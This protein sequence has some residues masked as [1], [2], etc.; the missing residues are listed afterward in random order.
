MRIER[1]AKYGFATDFTLY[2]YKNGQGKAISETISSSAFAPIN[3]SFENSPIENLFPE[4]GGL[5][6][7]MTMIT[8][9]EQSNKQK[10][11]GLVHQVKLRAQVTNN[12][13]GGF[14]LQHTGTISYDDRVQLTDLLVSYH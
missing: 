9:S 10:Q 14:G 2:E 5:L 3:L 1:T 7:T 6:V 8:K 13:E 4:K 11:A 12:K